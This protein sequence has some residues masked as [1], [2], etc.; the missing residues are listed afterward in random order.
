MAEHEG[1][2]GTTHLLEGL[3]Q[4]L[5]SSQRYGDAG[6][7]SSAANYRAAVRK[8]LFFCG[9]L[10]QTDHFAKTGSRYTQG[11][12]NKRGRV[13]QDN[14]EVH[15]TVSTLDE[16]GFLGAG[17]TLAHGVHLSGGDMALLA[18]RGCTVS[19]NPI[20]NLRLG[21]GIANLP[22]MLKT[23]VNVAL[24][25]DGSGSGV[26]SQDILE[27]AKF[28]SLIH[29]PHSQEYRDWP[30]TKQVPTPRN[31]TVFAII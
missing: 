2:F 6:V 13:L 22:A 4:P 21:A 25:V 30:S 19:H 15:G 28:A 18:E 10:Y 11:K 14:T 17:T 7:G 20:S 12:L 9:I 23:G 1:V 29:N 3:H 27:V 31:M 5:S 8:T 16:T 24:G 26:D